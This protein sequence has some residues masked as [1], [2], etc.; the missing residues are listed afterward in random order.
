MAG[1]GGGKG[2][3]ELR[4]ELITELTNEVTNEV[5]KELTNDLTNELTKQVT[6]EL[7]NVEK[8]CASLRFRSNMLK[9]QVV[10]LCLSS[11]MLDN[12]LFNIFVA[13][14][15]HTTHILFLHF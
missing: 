1:E 13:I 6:N 12:Q 9:A 14:L 2:T 8:P 10:L 4:N 11:K 3:K 5:T 7:T 15:I